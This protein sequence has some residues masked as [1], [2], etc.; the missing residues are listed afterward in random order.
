MKLKEEYKACKIYP[1]HEVFYIECIKSATDNAINSWEE[2]NRIIV[3]PE[4]LK[5]EGLKTIDLSENIVNQA[6]IISRY[7]YP[8]FD[9]KNIEK[10]KIHQLRSEKLKD[11]YKITDGNILKKRTFRNY[12]EHFDENLDAFLNNSIAGNILPKALIHN[13]KQMTSTTY[14]FKAYMIDEFKLISLNEEIELIALVEEIYRIDNL[15][16]DFLKNGGR[17]R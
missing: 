1:Q 5:D 10:N 11:S 15:S 8:S 16:D 9:R 13:S 6:G 17:L 7:F 2:L 4:L 14:A 12:I 3:S